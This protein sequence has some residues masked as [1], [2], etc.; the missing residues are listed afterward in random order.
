MIQWNCGG[1]CQNTNNFP[2][3]S[4]SHGQQMVK[5][6]ERKQQV[7]GR[8]KTFECVSSDE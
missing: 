4:E 8:P 3:Q 2:A 7:D 1:R 5:G 6:L